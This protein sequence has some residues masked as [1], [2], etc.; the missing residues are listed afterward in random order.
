MPGFFFCFPPSE[1]A[2][3]RSFFE[4]GTQVS[5]TLPSIDFLKCS[6][7]RS[8]LDASFLLAPNV[9]PLRESRRPSWLALRGTIRTEVNGLA[10]F[11]FRLALMYSRSCNRSF[12]VESA[13]ESVL[14][15]C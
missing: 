8:F 2:C 9:A 10:A 15:G 13:A 12:R 11:C 4:G 6:E 1:D 14:I 3:G 7:G 5:S